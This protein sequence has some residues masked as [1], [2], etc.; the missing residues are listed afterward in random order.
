MPL[1][2]G[3]GGGGGCKGMVLMVGVIG[4]GLV[5]VGVELMR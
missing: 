2:G 1:S 3:G 5:G 4:F